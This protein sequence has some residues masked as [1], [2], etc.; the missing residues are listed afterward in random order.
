MELSAA[1]APALSAELDPKM[2][3]LVQG[4]WHN[5]LEIVSYFTGEPYRVQGLKSPTGDLVFADEWLT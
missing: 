3:S 4:A 1:P 5:Y 2:K